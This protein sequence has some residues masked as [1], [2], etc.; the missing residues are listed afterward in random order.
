MIMVTV[1]FYPIAVSLLRSFQLE[2]GGWGP[3]NYYF[4]LQT[5]FSAGTFFIHLRS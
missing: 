3:D 5:A 4:S 1:I 2:E